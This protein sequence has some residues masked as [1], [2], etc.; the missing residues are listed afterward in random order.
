MKA[1]QAAARLLGRHC[2]CYFRPDMD[3]S[4]LSIKSFVRFLN[5]RRAQDHLR[6]T[7]RTRFRLR[8][9]E[10]ALRDAHAPIAFIEIHSPK[11]RVVGIAAFDSERA[12]NFIFTLDNPES[13][14]LCRR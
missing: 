13:V 2:F 14:A 8:A 5:L 3:E 11:L 9:I 4:A 6:E 1:G 12:D 7:E 10:H